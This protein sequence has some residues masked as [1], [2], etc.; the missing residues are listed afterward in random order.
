MIQQ[1]IDLPTLKYLLYN[2]HGLSNVLKLDRYKE[3]DLESLGL[4]LDSVK[5]FSDRELFPYFRE[6]DESPAAFKD[7]EVIVHE[8]VGVMMK[9]GGEMGLIC[10]PLDYEIGGLQLPFI[11]H[12][13]ATY[14][15][16]T[17]NNHL[18]G[19]LTLTLGAAELIIHFG[20]TALKDTYIPNMLSGKWGGTMCLTEPD[21]G[22]SLSDI[23]TKAIPDKDGYYKIK[24]QKIFISGGDYPYAENI[25]HLVLA[26]IEGAPAGTKGI[27]LFVVPKNRMEDGEL[28]NNDVVTLSDFKK[29]GQRG[30][31][32]THLGFGDKNNCR[33]WL[34]GEAHHGLKYMFQMM[35]DARI[36]VGRGAAAITMAAYQA[37]LEY[38]R[39]RTQGRKLRSSGKKNPNESPCLII[40]HPDV[41]R[42]LLLQ[43]TIAEGSLSLI[44]LAAK[45]HDL[46]LAE[47][48]IALTKK[49]GLLLEMITPIVKTYPS[50]A[51]AIAVSNG[52]QVL[53]GYGFCTDYILQQYYRDIRIFSIY[54]GTTGIQSQ[55]LLGRKV[56]MAHG[57]G[58][59]L[60][61]NEILET[62]TEALT[63]ENLAPYAKILGDKISLTQE[64][65]AHLMPIAKEGDYERYL[66]DANLFM[67]FLSHLVLGWVW[68]D[69]AARAQQ[70][71]LEKNKTYST[72][73]YESKIHSMKFYF[74]YELVKTNALA[75]SLMHKDVLTL[76]TGKD[77]F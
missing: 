76:N 32:T 42:M 59:E 24:G 57:K 71:M 36:G 2:V 45:Y 46:Q 34:L 51:G 31:A 6:M 72:N 41:R 69:I 13:A 63:M 53:G 66:A 37:S 17:A 49:Y 23:T 18:P 38:A 14:I 50:E 10:G 68:L 44:L 20:N 64:V 21:A 8:Q 33:G 19:Y 25:V 16:D 26:R 39:E 4:F 77:Y 47:N 1:Y 11:V 27:S 54:E 65:T 56:L 70:N 9:K 60:L 15:L 30:F 40:E 7:G 73:F 48:D 22:S 61:L 74:K 28:V 29:M 75:E 55:D 12:T 62:I 67:E 3:H 5:E 58:L 35:N 43:K 52:L